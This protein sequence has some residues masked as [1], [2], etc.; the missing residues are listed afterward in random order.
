MTVRSDFFARFVAVLCLATAG[1]Q[2]ATPASDRLTSDV[3]ATLITAVTATGED[4]VDLVGDNQEQGSA[5]T[6]SDRPET[7][8]PTPRKPSGKTHRIT[9]DDLKIDMEKDSVFDPSMLTDRV[10][11][12]DGE[13]VEI[14]GF[15]FPAVFQAT[16]I[17]QFPMVMNTQCKFG[18]GGQA[19]H[20]IMIELAPGHSTS[21][22]VRPIA[23]EGL[24]AVR[25]WEGPDGNTW[26][27]YHMT[28]GKVD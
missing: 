22:T 10:K 6:G 9:F 5:P 4:D 28:D 15:I 2:P 14:R 12:L 25:A 1:C 17:T 8:E 24:L 3:D 13:I 20:I 27:L 26:A 21:Y 18:P 11:E 7:P 16:G 19:H 23:V